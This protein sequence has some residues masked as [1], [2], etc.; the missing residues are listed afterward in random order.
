[1]AHLLNGKTHMLEGSTVG[2]KEIANKEEVVTES[3]FMTHEADLASQEAGK[4]ADMVGL[5]D[6]ESL[7]TADDVGGAMRELF[8]FADD[9]KKGIVNVVGAPATV[10]DTFPQLAQHIQNAKDLMYIPISPIDGEAPL[11]H[12]ASYVN[13]RRNAIATAVNA[14]GVTATYADTLAQL[15]TKIGQIETGK[16]QADG[17]LV[18]ASGQT[19]KKIVNLAFTPSLVTIARKFNEGASNFNF[20]STSSPGI[21]WSQGVAREDFYIDMTT[22]STSASFST[23]TITIIHGGFEFTQGV[24]ATLVWHAYE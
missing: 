7:F 16:K 11:L 22:S 12:F 19:G 21:Y 18:V 6:P 5:H 23:K 24:G 9:G 13:S 8:T 14:K 17:E 10:N 2:G 20:R 15:A 3:E 4:G 1:M